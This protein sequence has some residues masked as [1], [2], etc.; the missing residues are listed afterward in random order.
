MNLKNQHLKFSISVDT[1]K[2]NFSDILVI[3]EGN[4]LNINLYQRSTDKNPLLYGDFYIS[5]EEPPY[6][7]FNRIRRICSLDEDYQDQSAILQDRFR[8]KGCKEEWITEVSRRV[9]KTSQ[10]ECLNP[11]RNQNPELSVVLSTLLLAET[12]RRL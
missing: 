5:Q 7:T 12:L 10:T 1:C 4:A 8:K 9:G 6:F 2:M 11:K 3:R